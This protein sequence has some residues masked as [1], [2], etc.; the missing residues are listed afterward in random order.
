M[1]SFNPSVITVMTGPLLLSIFSINAVL[2]HWEIPDYHQGSWN[3]IGIV[4]FLP[5]SKASS[6]SSSSPDNIILACSALKTMSL[7]RAR[8]LITLEPIKKIF[9]ACVTEEM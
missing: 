5:Y 6:T 7:E 8:A 9:K 1:I 3:S 4:F 2:D